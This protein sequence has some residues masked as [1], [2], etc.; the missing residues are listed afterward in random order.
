M[1]MDLTKGSVPLHLFRM[2]GPMMIG[3]WSIM[4]MYFADSYFISKLGV[5]PLAAVGF[6]LPMIN[7]LSA[8]CFSF[9]SAASSHISRAYGASDFA[10]VKRYASQAL[11]IAF[12]HALVFC[13]FGFSL[14]EPVF[15][16][17]GATDALLQYILEYADVWFYGCFLVIIPMVSNSI[18]RATGNTKMPGIIM[19]SVSVVNIVLDPLFIFGWGPIPAMGIQGA[20]VATITAYSVASLC[21]LYF[22]GIKLR[23]LSF[24]TLFYKP[25]EAWKG[26][27]SLAYPALLTNLMA[28]LTIGLTTAF[29]AQYG[30]NAIAGLNVAM[31][32]ETLVMV[33]VFGLA[34]VLGPFIGQNMGAGEIGRL[35]YALKWA[36][37]TII[38]YCLGLYVGL[39][40]LG[41]ELLS[42]F[43]IT[44]AVEAEGLA[45][46]KW[47]GWSY[48]ALGII[49]VTNA[50]ANVLGRPMVSMFITL[51][52]LFVVYVP[53]LFIL[54]KYNG[55]EGVYLALG[56]SAL[57]MALMA[58]YS[59]RHFLP[60]KLTSV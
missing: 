35:R 24:S 9:G 33:P 4:I 22:L 17:L 49:I 59:W 23:Y 53:L 14:A 11:L 5:E 41:S 20:A 58:I 50:S 16:A 52:R 12:G 47:V 51:G 18:I 34:S 42:I 13:L 27:L 3:I 37:R 48:A 19:L 54:K 36:V 39:L 31:R 56:L 55:L 21:S 26:L 43:E 40:F 8:L 57:V 1:S 38:I 29:A 10:T 45:Y 32:L 6:V 2:S 44:P 15:R 30:V 46:I 25:L 60:K 7:L 28:P